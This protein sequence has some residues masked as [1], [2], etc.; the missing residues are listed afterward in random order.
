MHVYL[1]GLPRWRSSK[2]STSSAG[3]AGDT[4]SI[5]GSGNLSPRGRHD[6]HSR[7]LVW[8]VPWAEEL[9]RPQ[10]IGLQRMGHNWSDLAPTH[11]PKKHGF[12]FWVGKFPWSRK[13]Q[14]TPIFLPG[15]FHEQ[16]SPWDCKESDM[17]LS[18]HIYRFTIPHYLVLFSDVFLLIYIH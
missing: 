10:P 7:I 3:A 6:S 12:S 9:G 5:P 11:P 2:E 14:A 15:K 8:R 4:D 13:W 16:R 1:L 17:T 18:M